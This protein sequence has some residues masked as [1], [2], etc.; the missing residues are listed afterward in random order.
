VFIAVHRFQWQVAENI[1][2]HRNRAFKVKTAR[3]EEI[4]TCLFWNLSRL[5]LSFSVSGQERPRSGQALGLSHNCCCVEVYSSE[6]RDLISQHERRSF[7]RG[8][9]FMVS[10]LLHCETCT[11]H[12][13]SLHP[14]SQWFSTFS[15]PRPNNSNPPEPSSESLEWG[16]LRL[17]R[18]AWHSKIWQTSTYLKCFVF[19]FGVAKP[20]KALRGDRTATHYN[21]MSQQ[22]SFGFAL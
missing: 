15:V 22:G 1:S 3:F 4:V 17:C 14:L 16:A 7:S 6:L 2:P 10:S 21:P 13:V 19:E 12:H 5:F 9:R 20:N 18:R 8:G 11:W